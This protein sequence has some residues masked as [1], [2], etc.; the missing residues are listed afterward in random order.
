MQLSDRIKKIRKTANISQDLFAYR[1]GVNRAHISKIETGK[2]VPSN[3]LLK[4]IC[5]EWNV[6]ERWLR[7]GQGQVYEKLDLTKFQ[8]LKL[9]LEIVGY[10]SGARSFYLA[11][12][13]I[14]GA[15]NLI[16]SISGF[17]VKSVNPAAI[18]FLEDKKSFQKNL[19][20][21]QK[22]FSKKDRKIFRG[23]H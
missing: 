2:A 4:S 8:Q 23:F 5:R 11:T 3:Q 20:K 10:E 7:E 16:R 15:L 19:N 21:L 13:A 14:K 9:D 6:R 18:K 22:L 1:L 12:I 17:K